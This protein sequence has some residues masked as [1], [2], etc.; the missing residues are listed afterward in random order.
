MRTE[1]EEIWDHFE[2]SLPAGTDY[3]SAG[4]RAS[5]RSL[6]HPGLLQLPGTEH[7]ERTHR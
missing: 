5:E 4:G 2:I 3:P 6:C 7:Y 1:N